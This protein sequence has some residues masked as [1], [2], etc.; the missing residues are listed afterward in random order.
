MFRR[1]GLVLLA[2]C[3][4][5]VVPTPAGA[6]AGG[7]PRALAGAFVRQ[8][9]AG[10][11]EFMKAHGKGHFEPFLESQSPMATVVSCCDSRVQ[12]PALEADADNRLFV[13]RDIGN[14]IATAAGSVE[15]GVHHL[16][17]PVLLILGHV[18]CGAVR[19][20]MGDYSKESPAIRREIDTLKIQRGTGWLENV[21]RNV[22]EQVGDAL[23]TYGA[24]VEE[25]RLTVLGA[26]YDF[27]DDLKQGSGKVVFIN[28]NGV[29]DGAKVKAYIDGCSPPGA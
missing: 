22:D 5:S 8:V 29:T 25:G 19:A 7:D 1:A 24:D 14:Q 4:V 21:E 3:A 10:N 20:A 15:Y 16:H 11:G 26:V 28:V 27:A 23:R 18:R 2:L 6:P 9:V 13:I 17:T 12:T